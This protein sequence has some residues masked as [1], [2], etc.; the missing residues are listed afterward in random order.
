MTFLTIFQ[1]FVVGLDSQGDR[2]NKATDFSCLGY[3]TY[4]RINVHEHLCTYVCTHA[5]AHILWRYS[6]K[7]AL[8]SSISCPHTLRCLVS[9]S[10]YL[11]NITICIVLPSSSWFF[12]GLLPTSHSLYWYSPLRYPNLISL[13]RML[14]L[15]SVYN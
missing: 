10:S 1:A 6:S 11:F 7:T 8:A 4:I 15:G 2:E 5:H 3:V 14:I 9:H 12:T 13:I